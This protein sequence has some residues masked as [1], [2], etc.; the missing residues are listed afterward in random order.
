M[1]HDNDKVFVIHVTEMP[2][3]LSTGKFCLIWLQSCCI[4]F[5]HFEFSRWIW[6]LRSLGLLY[7]CCPSKTVSKGRTTKSV[8]YCTF[9]QHIYGRNIYIY[10]YLPTY[11]ERLQPHFIHKFSSLWWNLP[12]ITYCQGSEKN[13][14]SSLSF[15]QATLMFLLPLA[16][17]F[18]L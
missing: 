14:N 8:N 16:T 4:F 6:C 17:S 9:V 7:M 13:L 3:M 5:Q 15:G 2:H 1:K 10:I 11:T 12:G 18:S